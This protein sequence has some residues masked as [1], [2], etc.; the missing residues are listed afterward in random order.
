MS[1]INNKLIAVPNKVRQR[2]NNFF[3]E[4]NEQ[5]KY[6]KIENFFKNY[7]ITVSPT[8]EDYFNKNRPKKRKIITIFLRFVDILN[9]LRSGICAIF[10]DKWIASLMCDFTYIFVNQKL[11]AFS[12]CMGLFNFNILATGMLYYFES[13]SIL[14]LISYFYNIKIQNIDYKLN[15]KY[16]DKYCKRLKLMTTFL[17]EIMI[18]SVIILYF[19][20]SI[21]VMIVYFISEM[22]ISLYSIIFW[23]ICTL[24]SIF[25]LLSI[26]FG[27]F[28]VGYLSILHMKYQFNQINEQ[29]KQSLKL[30]NSFML[31]KAIK[32]HNFVTQ[33]TNKLNFNSKYAIFVG[34]YFIKLLIN[35]FM[36]LCIS[37][38]TNIIF[39]L[40][41]IITIFF[42]ISLVFALTALLVNLSK[43]AHNPI[44]FLYSFIVQNRH[45]INVK[46]KILSFIEK[47]SGPVIGFYCYDFFPMNSYN[48]YEY[49][50]SYFTMYLLIHGLIES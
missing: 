43:S 48:F 23:N 28:I 45:N 27:A 40:S 13:K 41:H 33:N 12:L 1:A 20:Y 32:S 11:M 9:I 3:N 6:N 30:N 42:A 25:N 15:N 29:I 38:K 36:Y 44:L 8:F 10:D 22:N 26:V 2:Y 31:K 24:I 34:Y 21:T 47:L 14:H 35:I 39:R 37:S 4:T 7:F 18:I 46:F 16:R 19:F 5:N 50:V 17:N 49:I